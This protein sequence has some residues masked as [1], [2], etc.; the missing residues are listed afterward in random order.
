MAERPHWYWRWC[1]WATPATDCLPA[2]PHW[3]APAW[4]SSTV[5][6]IEPA[7]EPSLRCYPT[8]PAMAGKP[9]LTGPESARNH[10]YP[11]RSGPTG[12]SWS[13]ISVFRKAS[14]GCSGQMASN[15]AKTQSTPPPPAPT[16]L[17]WSDFERRGGGL[18]LGCSLG[19]WANAPVPSIKPI[20][21]VINK[22]SFMVLSL[23]LVLKTEK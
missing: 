3:S 5:G 18:D 8:D 7:R 1:R 19:D 13:L 11:S 2:E 23:G 9:D 20:A 15:S 6:R 17:N 14:I 12:W 16:N 21:V 22:R 4:V 10:Y